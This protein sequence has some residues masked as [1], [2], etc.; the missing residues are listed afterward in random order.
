MTT[1]RRKESY[2]EARPGFERM[3][4]TRQLRPNIHRRRKRARRSGNDRHA[5]RPHER[6]Q[7]ALH[8]QT[9]PQRQT[10]LFLE[11][12][13]SRQRLREQGRS[14]RLLRRLQAAQLRQPSP[15]RRACPSRR[16]SVSRT[17]AALVLQEARSPTHP[18][19][20][21]RPLRRYHPPLAP[22]LARLP[23]RAASRPTRQTAR[24]MPLF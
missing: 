24:C 3:T 2:P 21:T 11:A 4:S 15:I 14:P 13:Q 23:G 8:R 5:I 1:A 22:K 18:A 9:S 10:R 16:A 12:W 7:L 17:T 6:R 19:R 20:Q